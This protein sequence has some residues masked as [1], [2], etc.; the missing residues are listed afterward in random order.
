VK[1]RLEEIREAE[2]DATFVEEVREIN[3][4]LSRT[5][6]V[7]FQFPTPVP[8]ALHHYRVGQDLFLRGGFEATV[9]G[10]C[11]RCLGDYSFPLA[12]EFRFVLKPAVG[13][14]AG[15][16]LSEEDL[17]L[18]FYEGD[19]VDLSPLVRE[20]MMLALPTRPLCKEDCRGLC[21]QCG[22]NRN[23]RACECRDEWTDPRLEV[24]RAYPRKH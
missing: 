23:L 22:T 15:R 13:E 24:L 14:S 1:I 20:A 3:D 21:P 11:A 6:V 2:K 7:D 8:V 12:K 9:T 16:E 18:S 10:T 5:G 17:S 4:A 19:E